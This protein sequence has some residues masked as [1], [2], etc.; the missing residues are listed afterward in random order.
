MGLRSNLTQTGI[1]RILLIE[2]E[3]KVAEF[4][5]RGLRAERFAVDIANDG[6]GGCG[7]WPALT[8]MIW[9]S[10]T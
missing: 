4:V 6:Q 8:I 10:W 5:G 1:M 3:K 7:K 9:S 2:D